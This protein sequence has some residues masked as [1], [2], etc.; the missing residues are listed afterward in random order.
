MRTATLIVGAGPVGLTMAIELARYGVP[1]RLIDK[2]L[3]RTDKS[4]A[5]VLWSRT[6]ELLDRAGCSPALIAAGLKVRA[7]NMLTGAVPIGRVGLTQVPGPHPYA[8]MLAQ[9]ETER[10]LAERLAALGVEVERGVELTQLDQEADGVQAVLCHP[11]GR[12]ET[13]SWRWLIACDGAHSTVRHALGLAFAGTT[14]S[15]AWI[16]ADLHLA[17][18]PVPRD[19]MALFWHPEG[20]VAAF[21]IPPDRYRLIADVPPPASGEEQR[22]PTLAEVQTILARRGPRGLRASDAVWLSAFRINERK[23]A[24]YRAGRVFLA[25]DAA[26]VHSPAGGQGM[27]TGMQD[28]CNLAWKLALVWHGRAAE[29]LL[30][31]YDGERGAVGAQVLAATGRLTRLAVL[32]HPLLQALRNR[33]ARLLLGLPAVRR[34][35]AAMLTELAIAYPAGPLVEPAG[36]FGPGPPP[37]ARAPVRADEPPVGAGG[38]PRFALLAEAG[39]EAMALLKYHEGL[40][41]PALRPPPAPGGIWLV[42]PDGY[43]AASAPAGAWDAIAAMLRRIEGGGA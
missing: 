8:L 42:R 5:V 19:E 6:L 25:G 9:S 17:G 12:K 2:A 38:T 40:I 13:G 24:S 35:M 30:D 32:R 14:L 34:R 39:P 31:S 18:M 43:V 15:S 22:E 27:N 33:A 26:H 3:A 4:K 36:R 20:V 21:P 23:V 1:V 10:L 16:L 7:V 28:A 29:P 41:E 37:G 11:D